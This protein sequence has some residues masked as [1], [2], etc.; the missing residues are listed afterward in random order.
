VRLS[1]GAERATSGLVW[2]VRSGLRRTLSRHWNDHIR[3]R[4]TGRSLLLMGVPR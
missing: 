1:D 2:S 3:T 4:D